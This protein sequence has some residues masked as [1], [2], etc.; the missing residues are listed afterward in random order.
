MRFV[1]AIE[2][3]SKG[4]IDD[5]KVKIILE[6]ELV[7]LEDDLA[8]LEKGSD[9]QYNMS[10]EG[11]WPDSPDEQRA[12]RM[13]EEQYWEIASYQNELSETRQAVNKIKTF[14]SGMS[15]LK[16]INTDKPI[17]WKGKQADL[18]RIYKDLFNAGLITVSG[19]DFSKHFIR[20][21]GDEMPLDFQESKGTKQ[22]TFSRK[23]EVA[24]IQK[25][26]REM[27]KESGE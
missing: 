12:V 21:N 2:E 9:I 20:S 17:I 23:Q 11:G 15:N 4:N 13:S 27:E 8:N 14:L 7:A 19:R 3:W 6:M 10:Q 5:Y 25:R 26:I 22:D 24:A 18:A 1:E 16:T